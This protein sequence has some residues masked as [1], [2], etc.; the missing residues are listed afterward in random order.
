MRGS[1]ERYDMPSLELLLFGRPHMTLGGQLVE[2]KSRKGM[3][4]IAFLAASR[5]AQ[6]RDK[7]AGLLWPDYDQTRARANLRRTLYSVN[8]SPAGPWLVA[9]MEILTLQ[10][11]ENGAI[12]IRQF[13]KYLNAES[14]VDLERATALYSGDFLADFYL[15][16]SNPFEEW[17]NTLRERI[18]RQALDAFSKLSSQALIQGNFDQAE[19][20]ARRQLEIDDL[21]EPAWRQLMAS[22][23]GNDRR[24]EALAEYD[25]CHKL[26]WEE[27][28]VEPEDKTVE[29]F[30]NIR[31][32]RSEPGV[33]Q[34]AVEIGSSAADSGV[35]QLIVEAVPAQIEGSSEATPYRGL[36]A[37]LE[38]DA[39]YFFGRESF[40]DLLVS[41]VYKESIIAV[42]GPS[43]SG[44]TSVVHAGLL[45][46]LRQAE[47]WVFSSFRP[48]Q[49][50]FYAL[51]ETLLPELQPGLSEMDELVEIQK[52]V[53]AVSDG[54]VKL[55][56]VVQRI[57]NNNN[58]DRLLLVADQFEEL[59][60]LCPDPELRR[61]FLDILLELVFSQQYQPDPIFTLVLTMRADFLG[62]ALAH[63]PTA[64]AIQE[65]DV[66][67]GPMTR[68]ELGRAVANPA[69]MQGSEFETGLVARILDDV[70]DEPG[71]L[72]LLEFALTS[73]WE[74]GQHRRLT[75]DAYEAIGRVEGS[76]AAYADRV[77]GDFNE[78]DQA[79]ARRIF[80]QLVRPGEG[81]EDT[82]RL[83]ARAELGEEEWQLVPRLADARLIVS[84]RDPAGNETVEIVHEALIRSWGQL[85]HWMAQDRD[86]RVWQERLRSAMRQWQATDQDDGALLRGIALDTAL[87]WQEERPAD[88]SD[89]EGNYIQTSSNLR[90]KREL[91]KERQRRRVM[92][93]LGAGLFVALLLASLAGWQ[94]FVARQNALQVEAERI[95]AEE[96]ARI[97]ISR[98]LAGEVRQ[99]IRR[100]NVDRATLLAIE[101]ARAAETAE[102]WSA[103]REAVSQPRSGQILFEGHIYSVNS[104][105]WNSD[106]SLVLTA[107]GDGTARIWDAAS[108]QEI[109]TLAAHESGVL[110]A[111]WN[112]DDSRI[113]TYGEGDTVRV[114]DADSGEELVLISS[115]QNINQAWWSPDENK[116]ATGGDDMVN[117]WDAE[118]GEN[119]ASMSGHQD[120][121]QQIRW[122]HD[123]SRIVSN[124][125][126]KTA[127]IWDSRSGEELLLLE[128]HDDGVFQAEWNQDES[129]ILTAGIDGTIRIYDAETGTELLKITGHS[130]WV[131]GAVWN[132][133]ES[134]ILSNSGDGTVRVWDAETGEPLLK[135]E[136]SG[137][138]IW[139][140]AWSN[141]ESRILSADANGSVI[142]WDA[143]TG[144]E[145]SK[146]ELPSGASSAFFSADDQKILISEVANKTRIWTLE[147]NLPDYEL[148]DLRGSPIDYPTASWNND[149]SKILT[150]S[151][152]PLG[153]VRIWDAASGRSLLT[154]F[155]PEGSSKAIWNG[156]ESAILSFAG[157]SVQI[158]DSTTG[159]EV[160]MLGGENG[161]VLQA[162]WD[163]AFERILAGTEDG[164]VFVWDAESGEEIIHINH[165]DRVIVASWSRDEQRILTVSGNSAF[166]W[167]AETGQLLFKMSGHAGDIYDADWNVDESQIVTRGE[168]NIARVW[169]GMSG[170]LQQELLGHNSELSFSGWNKDGSRIITGDDD[171]LVRLWDALT[172]EELLLM[173]GH[174]M[175]VS[176]I[177]FNKQETR[178]YTTS[179]LEFVTRVWDLKTGKQLMA[180]PD[181]TSDKDL[182]LNEDESQLMIAGTGGVRR[183]FLKLDDLI[184]V[185]CQRVSRNFSSEEWQQFFGETPY[186][187]SCPR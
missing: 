3:A 60:T 91:E 184:E 39:P 144:E 94:W 28:G 104:A 84:G 92:V 140:T 182:D 134:Q 174:N 68:A 32:G 81:T 22:L 153:P 154:I 128:G 53:T 6:S 171:G 177:L 14:D 34:D 169:D 110:G 121:I 111:L 127:R 99:E 7:V 151:D 8:Q 119:L 79:T 161:F 178:L 122:N 139:I 58:A 107:G 26:L 148:P 120:F 126:D 164:S 179:Q 116:I 149:E 46:E 73:L 145:I 63:R 176:D 52:L 160:K 113:L 24:S 17:A 55:L 48:G 82:R 142:V 20:A 69:Q 4:L 157:D 172:G 87:G 30:V 41:A 44:K 54:E 67:L 27:L 165:D 135:M 18:R 138:V 47:N 150:G 101:A 158:Y 124:S 186:R 11:D 77:F 180:I 90:R 15:P 141:D 65:S 108:G 80:I 43:G 40:T 78:A 86:F 35:D 114:W 181:S 152:D 59:Y 31:E 88:I 49:R 136:G 156:D 50:P 70:G 13:A 98:Q 1:S 166:V 163:A 117:V 115:P 85:G 123:G 89:L 159:A 147:S 76:L 62:Q 118:T 37:F 29:L 93:G 2:F 25:K 21:R 75:H 61:H 155:P 170:E 162:E 175:A 183:Y 96:Q 51:A 83:A 132:Q 143:R 185:A 133:D 56:D 130:D 45:A 131:L 125:A 129:Q 95:V 12:D 173:T 10:P 42:I 100:E 105:Q 36:F 33:G 57:I 146:L 97:A 137:E 106:E 38:E 66:K 187:E 72:P 5:Q 71:N 16:D 168:D 74:K 109:L 9:E 112:N 23:A 19:I 103:L 64:D 102:S 167:D